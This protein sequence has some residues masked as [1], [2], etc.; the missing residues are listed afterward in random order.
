MGLNS[1]Y[2]TLFDIRILHRYF[3][4]EGS[5]AYELSGSAVQENL[6]KNRENYS[7]SAFMTISP[8]MRTRKVLADYKARFQQYKD[9]IRVSL[10]EIGD[11]ATPFVEFSSK[12]YL[13]FTIQI[14]D[15]FFENYTDI[16]WNKNELIYLSNID[17]VAYA[18]ANEKE[19]DAVPVVFSRL[20][21][22]ATEVP[23]TE[24]D[25]NLLND[26]HPNELVN[27][28]GLIRIHLTG[29]IDELS[30]VDPGDN[31]L[32]NPI[33]PEL[34]LFLENRKTKWRYFSDNQGT[35]AYTSVLQPLTKNGYIKTPSG[36][37]NAIQ[38]PNPDAKL[39]VED[40]VGSGEFY[41]EVYI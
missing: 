28:F 6:D 38:Y 18:P 22:Y 30:L 34:N 31:T 13:D 2:K 24:I 33:T 1:K 8:T 36:G 26:T 32:F 29:E 19:P 11:D 39:I 37:G 17:P 27:K 23:G 14:N 5:F 21:Q 7:L 10:K 4:D 20:S 12:F 35:I 15:Q 9:G 40:P 3:L 25:I 16:V 41:S